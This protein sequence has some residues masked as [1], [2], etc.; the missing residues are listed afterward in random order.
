MTRNMACSFALG[1]LALLVPTTGSAQT[2]VDVGVWTR[3]GGGRVVVG[4]AP[5]YAAP[6]YAAPVYYPEVYYPPVYY[7]RPVYRPV[8]VAQ[9]YYRHDRGRHLGWYKNNK[10]GRVV[11]GGGRYYDPYYAGYDY[12]RYDRRG[13]RR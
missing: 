9:P 2:F 11:Y 13:R 1:A 7:A 8:Y 12:G 10:K 3:G 6:V 5:V 4:G